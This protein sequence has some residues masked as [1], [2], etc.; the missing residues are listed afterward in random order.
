MSASI[1]AI[2]LLMADH[3]EAK[4]LFAKFESASGA[5]AQAQIVQ[6][7]CN[8][9]NVHTRIEEEIFYPAIRGKADDDLLDESYV[10]HDGA[11]VLIRDLLGSKPDADFYKAKVTVLQEQIEHHVK[12]EERQ[13]FPQLRRGLDRDALAQLGDAVVAA[14]S[15]PPRRGAAGQVRRASTGSGAR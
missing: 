11:K 8:A 3:R 13:V 1:D 2:D 12:E 6:M 14:K 7:L 9:L 4:K 15:S 10:E 5:A